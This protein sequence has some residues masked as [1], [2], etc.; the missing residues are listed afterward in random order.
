MVAQTWKTLAISPVSRSR[1]AYEGIRSFSASKF[2]T[3]GDAYLDVHS[4][5]DAELSFTD[6]SIGLLAPGKSVTVVYAAKID[7]ASENNATVTV[8]P[9]TATGAAIAN[10]KDVA[11]SDT[12]T[13]VE[14][15]VDAANPTAIDK[16]SYRPPNADPNSPGS[17]MQNA[18][19][20]VGT[21][22]KDELVCTTNEVYL[23]NIDADAVLTCVEGETISI[24]ADGS[25]RFSSA[26]YDL[27]WYVATDGGD[28]LDG[29][30]VVNGLQQRNE[31]KV[32]DGPG[33]S[34]VIGS[35]S[36]DSD[37]KGGK[38]ACGDI[39]TSLDGVGG[40]IDIPIIVG[41]PVK[42]TD[43]N[44]DGNLDIAICFT[45]RNG[46]NDGHCTIDENDGVTIGARADMYPGKA[47][48]C[49]CE[50]YDLKTVKV[51]KVVASDT[52]LP[53]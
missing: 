42:C 21:G 43:E 46:S 3:Q 40:N 28:A 14:I 5:N 15:L 39:F 16:D 48:G 33:S 36:W 47:D 23:D 51:T 41:L 18:Y 24:T 10:L 26:R 1:T 20:D 8:T 19:E 34:N 11:A 13:I 6:N 44:E 37:A 4:I 35:V 22:N 25:I 38:D 53:C 50:R 12:S 9:V 30:C 27:G 7:G 17:C 32:L 2:L 31:Y 49:Y 52:V 45:W 29:T